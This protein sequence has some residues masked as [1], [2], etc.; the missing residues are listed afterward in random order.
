MSSLQHSSVA[1]LSLRSKENLPE[2]YLWNQR[3]LT[4]VPNHIF[5]RV[6]ALTSGF[7][8]MFDFD[9]VLIVFFLLCDCLCG[10]S[11][12]GKSEI[13]GEQFTFKLESR[14]RCNQGSSN[15]PQRVDQPAQ[16]S[17]PFKG[18]VGGALYLLRVWR[19]RN[20]RRRD[21][22]AF[23]PNRSRALLRL[24]RFEREKLCLLDVTNLQERCLVRQHVVIDFSLRPLVHAI[25]SSCCND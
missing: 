11:A 9:F 8:D 3:A 5:C 25:G 19:H 18:I 12:F 10:M 24:D 17:K 1:H 6:S 2:P 21:L 7:A 16:V 23:A 4:E 22:V 20:E 15:Q 13:L 14:K